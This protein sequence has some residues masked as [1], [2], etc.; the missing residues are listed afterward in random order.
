MSLRQVFCIW[1]KIL[2]TIGSG[3]VG[4]FGTALGGVCCHATTVMDRWPST[5]KIG[6][7]PGHTSQEWLELEGGWVTRGGD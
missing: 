2:G 6:Q 3:F 4:V 5:L 1:G 7:S